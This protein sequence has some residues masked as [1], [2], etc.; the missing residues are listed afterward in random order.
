[1]KTAVVVLSF[2]TIVTW[3]GLA[4]GQDEPGLSVEPG[5]PELEVDTD[6]PVGP[7][8]LGSFGLAMVAV[9][10]GFGWE[11]KQEHED[12]EEARDSGDPMGE[13]DGLADDVRAHSITANVLMF[14]GAGLA[15]ISVIWLLLGG[16]DEAE[17]EQ[18]DV[19]AARWHP[20]VGAGQAAVIVQF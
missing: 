18:E 10:A 11:A 5:Q 16:D 1:M 3:S 20:A 14:T 4:R 15:A 13:M 19:A 6:L 2:L 12:W 17:G 9:G 8:M 7:L